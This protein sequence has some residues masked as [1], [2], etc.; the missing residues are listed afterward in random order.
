[1]HKTHSENVALLNHN[2]INDMEMRDVVKWTIGSSD[3]TISRQ[4]RARKS[5]SPIINH[6]RLD[7]FGKRYRSL[8]KIFV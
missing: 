7:T 5:L 1:M 6:N 3:N 8:E 4:P 2:S